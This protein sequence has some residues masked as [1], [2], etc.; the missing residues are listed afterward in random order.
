MATPSPMH[1][2]QM[3]P[4]SPSHAPPG[5]SPRIRALAA[6]LSVVALC[7]ASFYSGTRLAPPAPPAAGDNT[8][9]VTDP[10]FIRGEVLC[11][12]A[13]SPAI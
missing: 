13:W 8:N 11:G 10:T 6:T 12:A 7:G 3:D 2:F 5:G 9:A 1:T 4:S